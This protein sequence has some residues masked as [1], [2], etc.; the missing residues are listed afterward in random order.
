MCS[1]SSSRR[2]AGKTYVLVDQQTASAAEVLTAALQQNGAARLPRCVARKE[3]PRGLSRVGRAS[4]L[5]SQAELS[6]TREGDVRDA[7][8]ATV[9]A[10]SPATRTFGKGVIQTYQPLG[11]P[12]GAT[13]AVAVT[14]AK[15][16]TPSGDDINSRGITADLV[17]ECA[18]GDS[19]T[20]C[21]ARLK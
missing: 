20:D 8:Q 12:P 7:L 18:R 21:I 6:A 9:V 11:T 13:G 14:V 5:S 10:A 16:T 19:A 4:C 3:E 17:V 1:S 2:D 15:Y